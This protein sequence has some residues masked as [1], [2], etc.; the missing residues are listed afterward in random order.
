MAFNITP[1]TILSNATVG[2][3]LLTS[4]AKIDI[5]GVLDQETLQQVFPQ[6]RPMKATVRETAKVMDYPV[7]TGVTLSDHRISNP[8]EI[9]LITIINSDSYESAYQAIRN[10][11]KNATLLSVQTRTGTYRNMIISDMPHEEDP[12]MFNAITQAIRFREVIMVVPSSIAASGSIAN[13]APRNPVDQSM[14]PRG[15]LSAITAA[16]TALSYF[17]AISIWGQ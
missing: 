5:V 16:G 2:L 10:I 8:T 11:W 15:L 3:N 14:Q 13:Y 4:V 6:A 9:E 17:N 1:Q 7:E 12:D